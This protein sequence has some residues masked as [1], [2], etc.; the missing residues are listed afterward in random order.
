MLQIDIQNSI[1]EIEY[2][3]LSHENSKATVATLASS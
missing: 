1:Y 3:D 2:T